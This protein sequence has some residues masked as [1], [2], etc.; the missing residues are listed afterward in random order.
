M[1]KAAPHHFVAGVL[2]CPFPDNGMSKS[3]INTLRLLSSV[4]SFFF[5]FLSVAEFAIE[6]FFGKLI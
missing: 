4:F 1:P 5:L 2:L 6:T 3:S